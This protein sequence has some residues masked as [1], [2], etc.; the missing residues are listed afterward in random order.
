[1]VVARKIAYNVLIST[2]SKIL[3]TVLALVAIG[4]ITRYLGKDGFGKY[5][6]VMAFFS[7]F[8]AL[9]DLGLSS[10]ATREIS[11]SGVKD[12][13]EIMSNVFSL[14]LISCLVVV[15]VSPLIWFFPYDE[16]IKKGILIVAWAFLFSSAYQVLNGIFQ[17]NLAM[18]KVVISELVGKVIQVLGVALAIKMKLGFNWLIVPVLV[19][20]IASFVMVYFWSRKYV[21][22]KFSIN[23]PFWKKFL[24]ESYPIGLITIITFVYFKIDTIMLSL[25]RESSDVGIYNAAYKVVE[26]ITFFPGMLMGLIFPIMAHSIFSDNARFKDISNKTFKVLLIIVLPLVIGTLFLSEGVINLI[27]GAGFVES[28]DVL[29]MLVF[30]LAFIFFA[31]FFNS[32]L[33]AGN[34]Q[35]KLMY[36]LG[37]AAILNVSLNYFFIK[38]YSYLG[39]AGV[40]IFTEFFVAFGTF[41]LT[42]KYLEYTPKIEKVLGII[43]ASFFMA[44][45][46]LVTSGFSFFFRGFLSVLVYLLFLWIFR[47]IKTEEIT[48]IISKKGVK[49]YEAIP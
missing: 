26:N 28:A 19:Y 44:V 13:Q 15:L 31:N 34:H 38:K 42:A 43:S 3:A 4:L 29:R 7:F 2:V 16:E 46:L 9:S 10:I 8:S 1:M 40:A 22:I 47:A 6:T 33:I 21:K 14:R 35:K 11:R 12:E 25:V 27:G 17:K 36:V 39:A 37:L 24:K 49:E 18:D 23:I 5:A 48:S 45:I 20:M 32:V 30:S 41:Y